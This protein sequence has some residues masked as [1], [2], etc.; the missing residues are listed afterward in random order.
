MKLNLF[1]EIIIGTGLV[2]F[3]IIKG[4]LKGKINYALYWGIVFGIH[5]DKLDYKVDREEGGDTEYYR[6]HMVQFHVLFMTIL[7]NFSTTREM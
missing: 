6:L 5:Y 2:A 3:P 7:M 1:M 4:L